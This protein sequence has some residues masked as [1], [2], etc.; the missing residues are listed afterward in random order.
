M[1]VAADKNLSYLHARVISQVDARAYAHQLVR[2]RLV[3][4]NARQHQRRGNTGEGRR[5]MDGHRLRSEELPSGADEA[6]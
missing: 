4:I 2:H 1:S 3:P 6:W 5:T